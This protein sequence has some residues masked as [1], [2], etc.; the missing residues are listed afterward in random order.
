M[1]NSLGLRE[2]RGKQNEGNKDVFEN[3]SH[4]PFKTKNAH[5]SLVTYSRSYSQKMHL[6]HKA[7]CRKPLVAKQSQKSLSEFCVFK[8]LP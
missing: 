8:F 7:L 5:F 6:K 4:K 2:A 1:K 3:L